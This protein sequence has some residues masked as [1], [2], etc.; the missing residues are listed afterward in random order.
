MDPFLQ[1]LAVL[2]DAQTTREGMQEGRRRTQYL[3]TE[4]GLQLSQLSAVPHGESHAPETEI[5]GSGS[6]QPIGEMKPEI[7]RRHVV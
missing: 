4:F 6:L 7:Y 1:G 5:V 2:A 3:G